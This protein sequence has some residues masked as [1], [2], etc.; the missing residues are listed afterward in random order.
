[1]PDVMG[2]D[3]FQTQTEELLVNDKCSLV[4]FLSITALCRMC[5]WVFCL[6][7]F[8]GGKKVCEVRRSSWHAGTA[9]CG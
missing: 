6:G 5:L 9:C 2:K 3:G 4:P 7:F 1:M 8:S